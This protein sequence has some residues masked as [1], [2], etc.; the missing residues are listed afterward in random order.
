MYE[1]RSRVRMGHVWKS[2]NRPLVSPWPHVCAHLSRP[3]RKGRRKMSPL[4]FTEPRPASRL[5]LVGVSN[6][7]CVGS[8]C[9]HKCTL[10]LAI[11]THTFRDATP[12][13]H[14]EMS[15]PECC[16]LDPWT[17]STQGLGLLPALWA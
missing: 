17:T 13:E 3:T 15:K 5:G 6:V 8:L 10:S 4:P 14:R 1:G 11:W 16:C 12:T 7:V 9:I 2:R